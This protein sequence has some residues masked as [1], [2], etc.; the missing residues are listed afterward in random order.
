[1]TTEP[2]ILMIMADQLAAQA[3]AVYG[4]STSITPNLDRLADKGTVFENC[5]SNYPLC[6]PSRASMLSG[7]LTPAI[8]VW[9]NGSELTSQQ[10]T[11]AHH[12]RNAGYHT[13]LTGKMHFIGP[14]Q[15]HGF[16]ER[17]TTD[18]YPAEIEWVADW[19]AGASFVPS[20]TAMNGVVEAGSAIRTLQEDYDEEVGYNAEQAIFDLAR[21]DDGC[22][23][24]QIASFT[25]PHTPFV[26]A[27]DYWD[28]AGE[29][30]LPR[31]GKIPFEDLDY[32]S[33]ALFFAHGRHRH[34]VTEDALRHAR[35]AYYGMI[36]F[37]DDLVGRLVSALEKT[38]QDK[39]T[40]IVFTSDHGE[41]LGERGMWFKQSFFDWSARVPLIMAGPGI[42]AGRQDEVVSLVDL[43]PTFAAIGSRTVNLP[44]DGVSL[45]P[46]LEGGTGRDVAIS[47]YSGIGPCVP[48]RMVR[49]GQW[50]LIYTHGQPPLLFD[51]VEDPDERTNLADDPAQGQVLARLLDI[52]LDGWDPDDIAMRVLE[53]QSQRL[54]V[55]NTPGAKSDWAFRARTNDGERYVRIGSGG[56]DGTKAAARLPRADVV[57]PHFPPIEAEKIAAILNGNEPLPDYLRRA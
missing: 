3:L 19:T 32:F 31:V 44:C 53:S 36:I 47:D 49:Q 4:N 50:K 8:G 23:W 43:L 38:G 41:M 10:P 34:R 26:C 17:R 1:M 12:M 33:K 51:M 52:C 37:I 48:A 27:V 35:R 24:F 2:N 54:F 18:V 22:P 57:A 56:V 11:M 30:D 39:N 7:R 28:R 45:L 21:R 5:Y 55:K 6:V 29:P 9:D 15:M 14:D 40:V 46:L 42:P 25:S 13:V 20:A 16:D